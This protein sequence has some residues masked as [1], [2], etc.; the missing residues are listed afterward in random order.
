MECPFVDCIHSAAA[1][2]SDIADHEVSR[3]G[4]LVFNP[5]QLRLAQQLMIIEIDCHTLSLGLSQLITAWWA[6]EGDM[7]SD[8]I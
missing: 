3:P 2:E 8:T 4:A 7:D 5:R 1:S 6:K